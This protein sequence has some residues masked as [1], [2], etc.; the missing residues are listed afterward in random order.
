[1]KHKLE[2][3]RKLG[4]FNVG[5][6]VTWKGTAYIGGELLMEVIEK[7]ERFFRGIPTV[8]RPGRSVEAEKNEKYENKDFFIKYFKEIEIP[9]GMRK[10]ERNE[11]IIEGDLFFNIEKNKFVPCLKSVGKLPSNSFKSHILI[12]TSRPNTMESMAGIEEIRN[13]DKNCPD[14]NIPFFQK[15]CFPHYQGDFSGKCIKLSN[16]YDWKIRVDSDS[17]VCLVPFFK[18]TVESLPV[19]PMPANQR[20]DDGL[21]EIS[22]HDDLDENNDNDVPSPSYYYNTQDNNA[23]FNPVSD[24]QR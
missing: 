14:V 23:R 21:D 16:S 13:L 20:M 5:D 22:C 3:N 7:D 19:M 8:S 4:D 17:Q 11:L 10:I 6:I 18:K 1:M 24:F 9:D 2:I 15:N 12:V